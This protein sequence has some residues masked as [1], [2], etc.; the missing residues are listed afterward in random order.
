MKLYLSNRELIIHVVLTRF[1]CIFIEKY[2]SSIY[3]RTIFKVL[4]GTHLFVLSVF[5]LTD[6]FSIENALKGTHKSYL[7]S[8]ISSYPCSC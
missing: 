2:L 5:V 4:V 1:D 7:L 6:V 8:D 3:L